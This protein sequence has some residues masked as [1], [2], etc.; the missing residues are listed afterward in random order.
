MTLAAKPECKVT[1]AVAPRHHWPLPCLLPA[2]ASSILLWLCFYPLAWGWL[3]WIALVPLLFLVRADARPRRVFWS[4]Y[5]GGFAFFA[6]VLLWMTVADYRMYA[7]WAALSFYCAFYFPAAVLLVRRLDRMTGWPL[8]V[9]V[10]LVWT[11]LE[12][13]RSFLFTGFAWYFLG[14]TQHRFLAVIQIADVGGVYCVTFVLAMVN[15]WLAECLMRLPEIQRAFRLMQAPSSRTYGRPTGTSCLG[16]AV[17]PAGLVAVTL[18]YG[19]WRLSEHEF[20]AG[21]R[22]ALLQGNLDQRIRNDA[23]SA[24]GGQKSLEAVAVHY[25]GLCGIARELKPDLIVW[26]ET[27]YPH[28]WSESSPKL[29]FNQKPEDFREHEAFIRK[30]LREF[31]RMTPG[32]HLLGMNSKTRDE[33]NEERRWV[34]AVLLQADG[35]IGG[36]YDKIHRVPFGEYVPFMDWLPFMKNFAPY[37]EDYSVHAGSK[38]TRL[39]ISNKGIEH[40]FGVLICYEDTDPFLARQY[41]RHHADGPPVDFL[42]NM[43][44][45]G[46]FDGSSE[47]EEHLAISRFRAIETR[48]AM[49]R[50]VNM[51]ISAV[52]DS[53][54]RVQLPAE[55]AKPPAGTVWAVQMQ[56][57][58]IPDLPNDKWSDYKKVAGLLYAVVPIDNRVSPYAHVGDWLPGSCW[59]C[60][61]FG[62]FWNWRRCRAFPLAA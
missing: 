33:E 56:G 1:E 57:D 10:P 28:Y 29:S 54:G 51:G 3:G 19:V 34:S 55:I 41:G 42:V 30:H 25:A 35:H 23:A 53:N 47:H 15:A 20:R 40:T 27:S 5:L 4:A 11:A 16:Q 37:D 17:V 50:A 26:P 2:L 9:T 31:V 39:K 44:N 12:F 13:I 24:Q 32:N 6:P 22:V 18:L 49:V 62:I 60:I 36:R 7:T 21:P 48:R 8:L 52:I 61:A 59:A 58:G 43:S 38:L 46:W 14:H 45:D